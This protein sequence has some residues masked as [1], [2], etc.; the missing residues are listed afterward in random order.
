MASVLRFFRQRPKASA[1]LAV[2]LFD[3]TLW[4]CS[5]LGPGAAERAATDH[6]ARVF[7]AVSYS[8]EIIDGEIHA[9]GAKVDVPALIRMIEPV[10]EHRAMKQLKVSRANESRH[11]TKL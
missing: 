6:L 5:A 11:A 9:M 10:W 3:A 4:L 2:D 7:G 8:G 1:V